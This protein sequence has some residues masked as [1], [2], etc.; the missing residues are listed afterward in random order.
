MS[1]TV[2][3]GTDPR[4]R[5]VEQAVAAAQANLVNGQVP[6]TSDV[7]V[8]FNYPNSEEPQITSPDDVEPAEPEPS[9]LPEDSADE[10]EPAEAEPLA[11]PD[12]CGALES[13]ALD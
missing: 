10:V 8:G 9:D 5:L 3:V 11:V 1:G 2:T 4:E 7:T 13:C 12:H 6:A